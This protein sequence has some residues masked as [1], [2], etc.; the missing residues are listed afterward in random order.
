MG[1]WGLRVGVGEC[2]TLILQ[3]WASLGQH[4]EQSVAGHNPKQTD[5]GKKY[6]RV[7]W[8]QKIKNSIT[9]KKK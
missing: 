4:S 7:T 5:K 8:K 6:L 9:I 3:P 2:G 1:G